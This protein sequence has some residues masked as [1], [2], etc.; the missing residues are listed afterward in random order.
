M[1]SSRVLLY[2]DYDQESGF[3]H[4]SR[5][6]AFI[7][8]ISKESTEIFLSSRLN[9]FES[10]IEVGFLG[11][12]K[13]ITHSQ[14]EA[15]NFD[16][17]YVD[18]YDN[19]ILDKAEKFSIDKKIL[20]IDGNFVAEVPPWPNMVIDLERSSPRKMNFSGNYLFAD[21]FIHSGLQSLKLARDFN[22]GE[23]K[24]FSKLMGVVNFGGSLSID[25]YLRQLKSTFTADNNVS[26]VVYAPHP[27][28]ESLKIHY[29]NITNVEVKVFSKEYLY[30]L[31]NCDFLI[32]NSG[33][34]FMEGLY[35]G[36]PMVTFSLFPNAYANFNKHRFRKNVIHSGSDVELESQWLNKVIE[37]FQGNFFLDEQ[38]EDRS[39]VTFLD[40]N[41]IRNEL[42][43]R[44]LD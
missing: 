33:T 19:G 23:G 30:D 38:T 4:I 43:S 32:T 36:I 17:V 21:L 34:S 1:S 42:N 3:G 5:S 10:Q 31:K 11:G 26:Y 28:S 41:A 24:S 25:H 44:I 9:P 29:G 37:F 7:E 18:S 40:V 35:L 2:L 15:M 8:A 14:V 27:L 13:W 12:V 6:R 39:D 20:V 22:S 16:L